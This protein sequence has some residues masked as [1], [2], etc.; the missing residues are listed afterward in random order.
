MSMEW[1][2]HQGKKIFYI[3]YSGLSVPDQLAQIE[4]ATQALVESGASDNLTLSDITDMVVTEDFVN[5]SKIKGKISGPYTKKAAVVGVE[6]VRRILLTAVNA[7]S[8]NPRVPF[9]TVAEAKDWLV[10]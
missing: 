6:G 4:K 8:G 3:N 10:K 9:A 7:V 2:T 5:L 1:I